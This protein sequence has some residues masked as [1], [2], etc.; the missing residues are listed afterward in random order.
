MRL[1]HV[2]LTV[3][4]V[5]EASSFFKKHL[6]CK[7]AF[8]GNDDEIAVL[9]DQAGMY[10]NLMRGKDPSY[11]PTFH[12]GFDAETED[13]VDAMYDALKADGIRVKRPKHAWGSYTFQF[14]CPGAA[15][16]IEIACEPSDPEG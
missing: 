3:H 6:G 11:P 15:F 2:N 10:I 4:D 12:I 8:E 9:V 14:E 5:S 13:Q 1:D 16:L 7:E